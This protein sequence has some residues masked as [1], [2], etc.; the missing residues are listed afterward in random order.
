[1]SLK[2]NADAS[3][4]M[5]LLAGMV[6]FVAGFISFISFFEYI[7]T[8]EISLGMAATPCV[9]ISVAVVLV[10][11]AWTIPLAKVLLSSAPAAGRRAAYFQILFPIVLVSFLLSTP[12][13]YFAPSVTFA[14]PLLFV[15]GLA[16]PYTALVM[17]KW[18]KTIE[19][20]NLLFVQC[21]R[22]TY[23]FEMHREDEWIRCPYCGQPNL[24]P[25]EEGATGTEAGA[26]AEVE[27]EDDA[28]VPDM[29]P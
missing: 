20:K 7:D 22:C 15:G 4:G 1:V 10:F 13:A 24:N 11:I 18:V 23:V 26:E 27:A 17:R 19:M 9:I 14:F 21:F 12:Q 3:V 29:A 6:M 2:A 25:V 16:Y 8:G 28:A 5:A